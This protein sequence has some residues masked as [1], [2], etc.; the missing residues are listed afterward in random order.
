MLAASWLVGVRT[1]R[2]RERAE[3]LEEDAQ[4]ARAEAAAAAQ[5]AVTE[6]RRRIARELHDAVGHA[7]NVMV[8]Q[9][10]AGRFVTSDATAREVL[11]RIE[12]VGRTALSDLDRMLGLLDDDGDGAPREPAHG[13]ADLPRLVD[14]VRATGAD[15]TLRCDDLGDLD[16]E[17]PLGAAVFR[18]VQEALT[19]AVKHAGPARIDV[20]VTGS[21]GE[22]AVEVRDDGRGAAAQRPRD[23]GRGLAGMRERV[24]VLG[25]RLEAGPQAGGGFRVH[26]RLPRATGASGPAPTPTGTDVAPAGTRR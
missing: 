13:V 23:G 20:V 1:R 26:A 14:G 18:I 7:V 22:L 17:R 21:A 25:G 12:A 19:N 3:R 16:R 15:V 6:E 9:A 5:E 2:A 11:E 10:G 4:A 8:V 24:A